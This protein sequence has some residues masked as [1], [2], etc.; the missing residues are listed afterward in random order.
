[1]DTAEK[2]LQAATVLFARWGFDGVSVRDIC[3]EADTSSNA[4][5]YHFKSKE[6]LYQTIIRRFSEDLLDGAR[7][8]LNRPPADQGEFRVRL[9]IFTEETLVTFLERRDL[10]LIAFNEFVQMFPHCDESVAHNFMEHGRAVSDYIA[11]AQEKGIVREDLDPQA[12]AE[13][14]METVGMNV[15]CGEVRK[16]FEEGSLKD[17]EYRTEWVNRRLNILFVGMLIPQP[18]AEKSSAVSAP[19]R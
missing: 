12:A 13:L 11:R 10:M 2:I 6:N 7:R 5:H 8:A 1:M 9:Q 4:V 14:M 3:R 15:L 19:S 18:A 17:P 16:Q